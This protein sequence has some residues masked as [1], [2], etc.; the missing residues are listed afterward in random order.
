M[1][2]SIEKA[3]A[4][5]Q[6]GFPVIL[7]DDLNQVYSGQIVKP[8]HNITAQDI[9]LM[10]NEGRG[11][12]CVALPEDRICELHLSKMGGDLSGC[13]PEFT[14]SVEARHGVTT[15]ISASDRATTLRAI[16][17][18]SNAKE[19]LVSPGHIFPL[20]ATQLG[21]LT[22]CCFPE[23]AI[24][25]LRL[26]GLPTAATLCHC[27]DSQGEIA[28]SEDIHYLAAKMG[29]AAKME[30]AVVSISDIFCYRCRHESFIKK[31]AGAKLPTRHA[32]DFRAFCFQSL[33]EPG[34]H[35]AIVKGKLVENS[36]SE[37]FPLVRIHV[38][39][40]LGD[41]LGTGKFSQRQLI[42]G[43][44]Q[45][46]KKSGE[47][48]FIYLRLER[49]KSF[50]KLVESLKKCSE[51]SDRKAAELRKSGFAAQIL[52][53]FGI[54]KI[55]LMRASSEDLNDSYF[56]KMGIQVINHVS[57][58]PAARKSIPAHYLSEG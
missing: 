37:N 51:H 1:K 54:D 10:V 6:K 14:V 34:E 56:S 47:G 41:L 40:P 32:G 2:N 43:A 25:L 24:D 30:H 21:V 31:V 38:E 55:Q 57:F 20:K 46:I 42:A 28:G 36:Q 13:T 19:E 7:V 22:Q 4:D 18:T 27:L 15:G 17:N 12:I 33:L 9:S 50:R 49:E 35:L 16:A 58:Q 39:H 52:R 45:E 44:L 26:A 8:A 48:I 3:I 11:V 29:L 53:Y 23:A 5:L